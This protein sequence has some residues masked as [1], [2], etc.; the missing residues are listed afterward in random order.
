[1]DMFGR[2]GALARNNG[3]SIWLCVFSC[4]GK[5]AALYGTVRAGTGEWNVPGG[6]AEG[7]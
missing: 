6:R 4:G 5:C 2:I 1:M 3:S 7:V